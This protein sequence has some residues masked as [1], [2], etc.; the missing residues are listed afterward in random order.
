MDIVQNCDSYKP[1]ERFCPQSNKLVVLYIFWGIYVLILGA[2][3]ILNY[4][5]IVF[6]ISEKLQIRVSILH[7]CVNPTVTSSFIH[8]SRCRVCCH[9]HIAC[10]KAAA[11][12]RHHKLTQVCLLQLCWM[13]VNRTSGG[14]KARRCSI[15]VEG[16]GLDSLGSGLGPASPIKR[17]KRKIEEV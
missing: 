16:L 7:V 12:T 2:Q 11:N 13:G 9:L 8:W 1:T 5:R 4:D 17:R 15:R 6:V 3:D 14:C 10:D